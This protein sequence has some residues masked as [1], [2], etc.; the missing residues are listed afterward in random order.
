MRKNIVLMLASSLLF[1]C[2]GEE[3]AAPGGTSSAGTAAPPA[4]P[5]ASAPAPAAT[6]PQATQAPTA[7]PQRM[8]QAER[9]AVIANRQ[10][11]EGRNY[12]RLTPA[13]PTLETDADR[14]EVVE[15]FQY[16]CPACN[17]FEPY[18]Q[19]W[20]ASAAAYVNF[21]RL[22]AQGN[23]LSELHA[24][25]YYTASTLGIAE[26]SHQAFFD[27]FHRNR[28]YM[29]TEAEVAE[30]YSQFG[31][32]EETFLSTFNSFAVH[33]RMQR[34]RDMIERYRVSGTPQIVVAGK[35]T[36]TG[37]QAGSYDDWF[38]IIDELAAVEWANVE[39]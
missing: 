36:I 25:A 17:N 11:Q 16:S 23:Q 30:F 20:K 34:G 33:T 1:A 26:E 27:E 24:R 31:V 14:V 3:P 9:E 19:A 22:P 18:V 7:A 8:T 37:A 5:Q 6:Q 15:F 39:E 2:G 4:A 13:Q 35:Y 38:G 10:Y 12:T 21:V 32:D 28:N 29:Q